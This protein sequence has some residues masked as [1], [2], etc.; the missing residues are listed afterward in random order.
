[1]SF[2][3]GSI[4]W[5]L[6]IAMQIPFAIFVII[7]VFGLPESPRWLYNHDRAGDAVKVLCDVY[8]KPES[9]MLI[10]HETTQIVEAI[11][12]EERN[13][14]F[15]W[16]NVF[17]KDTVQTGRR[18][19]LAWGVQFMNQAGGINLVVYYIPCKHLPICKYM[20]TF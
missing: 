13:G 19:L 1:M 15:Q 8:D 20:N 7:L 5:R 3:S 4:A 16:R 17:K 12:L 11:A 10:V 14:R 2:T 9:D 6:P 18:V